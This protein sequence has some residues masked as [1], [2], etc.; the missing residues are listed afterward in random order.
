M[1]RGGTFCKTEIN[2]KRRSI[3]KTK[4]AS[5]SRDLFYTEFGGAFQV[6]LLCVSVSF[7]FVPHSSVSHS[8][9][10][11]EK[12]SRWKRRD[13]RMWLVELARWRQCW[14]WLPESRVSLTYNDDEI[15]IRD[16]TRRHFHNTYPQ[17]FIST[18]NW[19]SRLTHIA[20]ANLLAA[21]QSILP[22]STPFPKWWTPR[23][24]E[25]E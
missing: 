2:S 12:W 18:Y 3:W 8:T 19:Q 4:H 1:L 21:L 13:C 23:E 5:L 11:K 25:L 17:A 14:Q 7:S 24:L 22:A 16:N 9:L 6:G 20:F 15:S 10:W